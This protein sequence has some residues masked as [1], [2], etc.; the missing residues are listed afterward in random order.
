MHWGYLRQ[1]LLG[2][3]PW[4]RALV[5]AGLVVLGV[6]IGHVELAAVG[7][8]LVV[9]V[10]LGPLRGRRSTRRRQEHRDTLDAPDAPAAP[11]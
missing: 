3:R 11:D 5:G 4:Q 8:F 9:A 7:A 2:L 10:T 1:V 6:A